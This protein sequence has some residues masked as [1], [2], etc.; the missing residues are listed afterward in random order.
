VLGCK[1]V[2]FLWLPLLSV[3]HQSASRIG[4]HVCFVIF[5]ASSTRAALLARPDELAEYS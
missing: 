1:V 4:F 3:V 5:L 2:R